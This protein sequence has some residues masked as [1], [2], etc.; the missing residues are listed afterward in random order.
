MRLKILAEAGLE[1]EQA[2][3]WYQGQNIQAALG[4][5][6]ALEDAVKSITAQP[7]FYGLIDD[8]FRE[9]LVQGYPYAIYFE[10]VPDQVTLFAISH[11]AREPGYWRGRH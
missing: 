3:E 5:R 7:D 8:R 9:C 11:T 10:F 2:I 1:A 4:F 6:H